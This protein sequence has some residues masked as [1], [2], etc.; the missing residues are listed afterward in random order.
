M[1]TLTSVNFSIAVSL[2]ID[3]MPASVTAVF[4]RPSCRRLTSDSSLAMPASVTGVLASDRFVSFV[5]LAT[6]SRPASVILV[7]QEELGQVREP[8]EVI[9]AHVGRACCADRA[10][11]A[12]SVP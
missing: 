11:G 2:P 9:E 10:S 3:S 1:R 12:W 4:A 8:D 5:S 6:T 7:S